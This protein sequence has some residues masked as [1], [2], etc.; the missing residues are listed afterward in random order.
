MKRLTCLS[1]LFVLVLSLS[2]PATAPVFEIGIIQAV[3]QDGEGGGVLAIYYPS[4][5]NRNYVVTPTTMIY[6]GATPITLAQL[7]EVGPGGPAYVRACELVAR[8]IVANP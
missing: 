4:G 2:A 7:A 3:D 5:E 8:K 6:N 1:L